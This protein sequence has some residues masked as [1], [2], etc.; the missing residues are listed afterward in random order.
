[1]RR[2]GEPADTAALAAFLLSEEAGWITGQTVVIDGG[3]TLT[4]P[5]AFG[6]EARA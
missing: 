5:G 1:M 3:I 6:I 2:L 4:D